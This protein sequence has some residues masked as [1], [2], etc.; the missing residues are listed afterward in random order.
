MA[1]RRLTTAS[2]PG[3]RRSSTATAPRGGRRARRGRRSSTAT[4]LRVLLLILCT[5]AVGWAG[6]TLLPADEPTEDRA[7][8]PA[9]DGG[10][11][12]TASAPPPRASASVA[13][14]GETR[15]RGEDRPAERIRYA[16]NGPGTYTWAKGTG[17]RAGTK[18]RL[19]RY[20][21]KLEHGTGLDVDDVAAEIDGILRDPRGWTRQGAA[22]FQR[23]G[24]PPY[25][26]L[27]HIV[28]PG[29]TDRLCGQWGLKT[30]GQ[31]NCAGAP[32]LVVNVRRWIELSPQ[33]LGRPDDYH[34]LIINHEAGHV[35]GH[36][37]RGCP[38][39]GRPAPA[40]MQQI[41]GL[42][43]CTANPWVYDA[44]GRLIDGPP[45]P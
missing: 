25:D 38:G 24:S 9:V 45:E 2:R 7:A 26:M 33:Y 27:I 30:R 32:H 36:G 40:M 8:P 31:V 12:R 19:V 39:R 29:T 20:G 44:G 23:V 4:A 1:D 14:S 11:A 15:S 42:K 10:P 3:R 18:G 13:A 43:G 37:H 34:A 5:A 17:P 16:V 6:L 28:S 21:V 35:L 22:S 41:K